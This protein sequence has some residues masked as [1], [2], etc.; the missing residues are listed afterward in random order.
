MVTINRLASNID[1]RNTE[2]KIFKHEF[3]TDRRAVLESAHVKTAVSVTDERCNSHT[4]GPVTTHDFCHSHE[5]AATGLARGRQLAPVLCAFLFAMFYSSRIAITTSKRRLLGA[6]VS[7]TLVVAFCCWF[8]WTRSSPVVT[9]ATRHIETKP[10]RATL[11]NV[12]NPSRLYLDANLPELRG[13]HCEVPTSP[14]RPQD[15]LLSS[16]KLRVLFVITRD[17]LDRC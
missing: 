6:F 16:K 12:N 2:I 7:L 9:T 8:G 13:S 17:L 11:P 1:V 4:Y 10:P 15:C 3:Q 5:R 14:H